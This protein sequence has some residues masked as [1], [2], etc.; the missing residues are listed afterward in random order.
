MVGTQALGAFRNSAGVSVFTY[1]VTQAVQNNQAALVP[2]AVTVAYSNYSAA[3]TAAGTVTISGTVALG[4]NQST[5]LN[6]VWNRGATATPATGGLL[7]HD[8][9]NA[10]LA[11]TAVVDMSSGQTTGGGQI[12]NLHL[13]RVSTSRFC[14]YQ[15]FLSFPSIS[16]QWLASFT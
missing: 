16:A 13:K 15:F 8:L 7:A 14:C 4:R 10:N 11:S 3:A 5:L 2:G 9:S 6:L 12:P 1:D